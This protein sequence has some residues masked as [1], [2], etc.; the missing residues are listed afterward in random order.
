[1]T[2]SAQ[3]AKQIALVSSQNAFGQTIAF[4]S[5]GASIFVFALSL[6]WRW[7]KRRYISSLSEAKPDVVNQ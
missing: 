7:F 6:V 1:V 3:N 2:A 4:T 5:I